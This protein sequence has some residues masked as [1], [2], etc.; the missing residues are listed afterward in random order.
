M[1]WNNHDPLYNDM[2]FLENKKP[3]NLK[4]D[5]RRRK[6]IKKKKSKRKH[7]KPLH[8]EILERLS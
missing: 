1:K 7:R 4:K 5:R 3:K 6:F 2:S 8:T